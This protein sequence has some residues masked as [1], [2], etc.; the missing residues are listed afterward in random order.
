MTDE[1]ATVS[2]PAH[3]DVPGLAR[4]AELLDAVPDGFVALDGDLT[5][6]WLNAAA[7]RLVQRSAAELIGAPLTEAFPDPGSSV[8][9]EHFRRALA[10]RHEVSFEFRGVLPKWLAISATPTGAGLVATLRDVGPRRRD[11]LLLDGNRQV[12]TRIAE[13]A[14]LPDVL[15]AVIE[16][17]ETH[18]EHGA[19]GSVL[20]LSDDGQHLLHGSAPSLP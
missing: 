16:M 2:E 4:L 20:L 14:P 3:A 10:E 7:S 15:E 1:P 19:L 9:L 8:V 13:N 5:I 11:A 12:L 18:S 6:L 17:V